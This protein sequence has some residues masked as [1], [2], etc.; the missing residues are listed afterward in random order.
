MFIHTILCD[1]EK[2]LAEGTKNLDREMVQEL[3][4]W[5]TYT[6]GEP[7]C[8]H[9]CEPLYGIANAGDSWNLE[10]QLTLRVASRY[11]MAAGRDG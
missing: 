2:D 9:V 1:A 11:M 10:E 3:G 7:Q 8:R 4:D 6:D 5:K